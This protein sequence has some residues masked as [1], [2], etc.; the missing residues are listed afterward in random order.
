MSTPSKVIAQTDRQTRRQTHRQTHR[1]PDMMK[2][3]PLPY[4]LEVI[5][6]NTILV[7]TVMNWRKIAY[8]LCRTIK[9]LIGDYL[10]NSKENWECPKPKIGVPGSLECAVCWYHWWTMLASDDTNE[11]LLTSYSWQPTSNISWHLPMIKRNSL[12][13]SYQ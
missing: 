2:T 9:F 6:K 3:L 13:F 5:K 12:Y 1:H 10:S 7:I 4:T 8:N 11:I